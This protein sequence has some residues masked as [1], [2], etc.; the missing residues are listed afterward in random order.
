[1]TDINKKL[2][3]TMTLFT[4]S[5]EKRLW[6]WAFI[7]FNTIYAT[8]FMGRPLAC[9]L[10]DQNVQAFFFVLGILL[11]G[12]AIIIH[13]VRTKPSKSEISIL[14]GII[15]V[16]VMFIFRLGASER[17]HVIEYSVLAIFIHKALVERVH[18]KK[19]ILAPAFLAL[20]FTSLIGVL[21]ECI[22]IILP[23]RVFDH[24]DI[25][26]NVIAVTMAIGASALL[27][28]VRKRIDRNKIKKETNNKHER[29]TKYNKH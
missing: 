5:R 24:Q 29:T 6:F 2:L 12:T 10:R 13:G 4:S 16:Y 21:D 8:L 20:I 17:S 14:L 27:T 3:N 28:C 19:L 23:N 1:M 25:L 7:V 18:Q 11:V 22:Q 15:A 9:Q 26:F